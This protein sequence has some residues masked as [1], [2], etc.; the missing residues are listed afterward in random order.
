M[1]D[2]HREP[3]DEQFARPIFER[4]QNAMDEETYQSTYHAGEQLT[5]DEALA[6]TQKELAKSN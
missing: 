1:R 2:Y 6:E 3:A 5:T 4:T